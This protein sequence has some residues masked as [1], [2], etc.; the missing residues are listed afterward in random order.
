[1]RKFLTYFRI[2][3][4][5]F[6]VFGTAGAQEEVDLSVE[7]EKPEVALNHTVQL[8][9]KIEWKGEPAKYE[10]EKFDNP[11][12]SNLQA[13][14]SSSSS[15]SE[16][17]DGITYSSKVF[18]YT[19][20]PIEL[21]MGYIEP[22]IIKY[23][24]R[25]TGETGRLFTNRVEVKVIPPV[26]EDNNIPVVGIIVILIVFAVFLT[27]I[28]IYNRKKR[29]KEEKKKVLIP[30]EEKYLTKL[31]EFKPDVNLDLRKALSE[32]TI[33]FR[34]YLGEKYLI[35][36]GGKSAG[37]IAELISDK[38]EDNIL[39]EKIENILEESD[40]YKFSGQ[41]IEIDKYEKIYGA[42]ESII[43]KGKQ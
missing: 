39:L 25:E 14:G 22:V 18:R 20:D 34:R 28:K 8:I 35:E 6:L 7:I 11:P 23:K 13:V 43:E 41:S 30:V 29:K 10:I 27:S 32:I 40:V 3:L 2:L 38:I 37:E 42:V 31:K 24:E 4:F 33:C 36:T 15:I 5:I 16:V 9:V 26:E 17:R 12:L 19:L 1:M 21:G